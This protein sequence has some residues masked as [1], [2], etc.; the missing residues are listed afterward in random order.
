MAPGTATSKDA[1][2]AVVLAGGAG[3]RMGGA[4]KAMVEVAGMPMLHRVLAA[5]SP[6]CGRV[7]VVGPPRP[8]A[9]PE[10][11]FVDDPVPAGGPVPAIGA[12]LE[13]AGDVDAVFVLAVDLPLLAPGDL[14]RLL[15]ELEA[16]PE[17]EAVTAADHRGL[18]NPLLGVYR[19][20]AIPVGAAGQPASRMLPSAVKVV[21]LGPVASL[22]VNRPADLERAEMLAARSRP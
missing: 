21:E 20:A 9:V 7:V 4:D 12:G 15:S 18:P 19:R 8:V 22:N 5:A 14:A 3:R 10:V 13:A 6:L 11:L 17:V 2:A 1:V 16:S